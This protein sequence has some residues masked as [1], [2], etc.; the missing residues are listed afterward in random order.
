MTHATLLMGQPEL[1]LA[2][3]RETVLTQRVGTPSPSPAELEGLRDVNIRANIVTSWFYK[4][5]PSCPHL[6]AGP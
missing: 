2:R 6:A 4:E 3:L 5:G 1:L